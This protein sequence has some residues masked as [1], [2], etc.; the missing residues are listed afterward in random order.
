MSQAEPHPRTQVL[1]PDDVAQM[2]ED[3]FETMLG[4]QIN[5]QHMEP[6]ENSS[7]D[8]QA[9][10]TINGP[11]VEAECHV[12]V[13]DNLAERIACAMFS[14]EPGE[15]TYAEILDAMGEVINVIGGNAKGA[16]TE[17]GKL[18]LPSVGGVITKKP[19]TAMCQT[20]EC[21]GLD[22]TIVINENWDS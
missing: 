9:S 1:D 10:A 8:I 5:T 13:P 2:A 16:L 11:N 22:L 14:A 20:Y 15:L 17:D 6:D 7:F 19:A 21:E 3:L 4:L 12:M 18:S